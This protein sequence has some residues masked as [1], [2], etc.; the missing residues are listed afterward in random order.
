M[1]AGHANKKAENIMKNCMILA[2]Q[3]VEAGLN[4]LSTKYKIMHIRM[5]AKLKNELLR[6]ERER[7]WMLNTR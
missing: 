1:L 7:D 3:L 4:L 5:K 2:L 6:N